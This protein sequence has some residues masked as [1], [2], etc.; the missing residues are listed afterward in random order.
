MVEF[1]KESGLGEVN[2][3]QLKGMDTQNNESHNWFYSL[4]RNIQLSSGGSTAIPSDVFKL[5]VQN[6]RQGLL[7]P[8]G[9]DHVFLLVS[10]FKSRNTT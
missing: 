7:F 6:W 5:T 4:H 10:L 2:G 9:K 8:Q 1:E 3:R